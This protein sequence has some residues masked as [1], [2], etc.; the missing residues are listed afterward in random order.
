M[1]ERN[2]HNS[3]TKH[4]EIIMDGFPNISIMCSLRTCCCMLLY[5]Y[6]TAVV[7]FISVIIHINP[8]PFFFS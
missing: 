4:L 5:I 1:P 7:Q 8:S 2:R 3:K 6:E